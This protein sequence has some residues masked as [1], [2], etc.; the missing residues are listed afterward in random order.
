[1]SRASLFIV[2]LLTVGCA[3]SAAEV[4]RAKNVAYKAPFAVVWEAVSAEVHEKYA[5]QVKVEDATKGYFETG[6][7]RV[8]ALQDSTDG[9][10]EA[11]SGQR[12][13]SNV[14]A[15]VARMFVR[16]EGPTNGPHTVSV[17]IEAAEFRPNLSSLRPFKH[18]AIDEPAWVRE[19]ID[20]MYVDV[21]NR[22]RPYAVEV[23]TG[24]GSAI[25][26]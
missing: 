9:V 19:R 4:N 5:E 10:S 23:K 8:E 14:G 3:A 1:M 24:E 12:S 26:Q 18:G 17:D 15:I 20:G 11:K 13:T 22:L 16:I 21:Y 7:K 6:W 25:G 2:T